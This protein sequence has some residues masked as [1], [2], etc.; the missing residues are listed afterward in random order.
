MMVTSSPTTPRLIFVLSSDADV[1]ILGTGYSFFIVPRLIS[2]DE[3][4]LT[5][6]LG[7]PGSVAA[8]FSDLKTNGFVSSYF[9]LFV[10][11][12]SSIV[13]SPYGN[14]ANSLLG[15]AY[16]PSSPHP[17]HVPGATSSTSSPSMISFSF[18]ESTIPPDS[19]TELIYASYPFVFLLC[20]Y[21]N[22][23]NWPFLFVTT[24]I[25]FPVAL[26]VI[27]KGIYDRRFWISISASPILR[28]SRFCLYT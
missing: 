27:L 8:G 28:N 4:G 15:S 10:Q 20:G 11:R 3:A 9:M 12:I 25:D 17:N 1:W 21:V 6:R 13:Y 18:S 24:Y 5:L 22:E 7:Y 14:A 2:P 23:L 16:V 26:F 19:T